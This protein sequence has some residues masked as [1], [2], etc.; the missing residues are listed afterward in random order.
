MPKYS[1]GV[2][3]VRLGGGYASQSTQQQVSSCR[4]FD[5]HRGQCTG[6]FLDAWCGWETLFETANLVVRDEDRAVGQFAVRSHGEVLAG[7]GFGNSSACLFLESK[8][9]LL[10]CER[11]GILL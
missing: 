5:V 2:R 9:L 7:R 3:R 11:H 6:S 8:F 4:C 1:R 10:C